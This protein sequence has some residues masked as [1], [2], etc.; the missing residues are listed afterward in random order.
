MAY[1]NTRY[2]WDYVYWFVH[3]KTWESEFFLFPTVSNDITSIALEEFA[4]IRKLKETNTYIILVIDQAGFHSLKSLNI[5][6]N[7][8]PF[9]LPPYSPELQPTECVWP[10]LREPLAN[11]NFETFDDLENTIINRCNYLMSNHEL[12]KGEVWFHWILDIVK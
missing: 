11:K 5:P 4:K 2:I 3:P 1:H 8:I 6:E 12:V 10:L 9:P 7:I